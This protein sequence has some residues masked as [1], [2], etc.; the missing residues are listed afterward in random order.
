M[1]ELTMQRDVT[2]PCCAVREPT[3]HQIGLSIQ[4]QSFEAKVNSPSTQIIDCRMNF[5]KIT[6]QLLRNQCSN[7]VDYRCVWPC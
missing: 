2:R 7:Y 3:S 6:H 4:L 1:N 5:S